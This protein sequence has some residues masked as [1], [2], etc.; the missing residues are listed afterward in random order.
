MESLGP[1]ERVPKEKAL[2]EKALQEEAMKPGGGEDLLTFGEAAEFAGV[3]LME[4][5]GSLRGAQVK[6]HWGWRGGV[7]LQLVS[8]SELESLYPILQKR[9]RERGLS[10]AERGILLVDPSGNK[11]STRGHARPGMNTHSAVRSA[12]RE[13]PKPITRSRKVEAPTILPEEDPLRTYSHG[14][15]GASARSAELLSELDQTGQGIDHLLK[16]GEGAAASPSDAKPKEAR[17]GRA[18][19]KGRDRRLSLEISDPEVSEQDARKAEWERLVHQESSLERK[20]RRV[21]WFSWTVAAGLMVWVAFQGQQMFFGKSANQF[22]TP[23]P[24]PERS[25]RWARGNGN[26]SHRPNSRPVPSDGSSLA[27][28]PLQSPFTTTGNR[29]GLV[30]PEHALA[31]PGLHS[32]DGPDDRPLDS[33]GDGRPGD[34]VP[35]SVAAGTPEAGT[36]EATLVEAPLPIDGEAIGTTEAAATPTDPGTTLLGGAGEGLLA[37]QESTDPPCR[38]HGLTG[39]GQELRSVLGPCIGPWNPKEKAV[40]GGVPAQR[41]RSLPPSLLLPA[42]R[43][44]QRRSGQQDRP[45]RKDRG[46]RSAYLAAAPR[47]WGHPTLGGQGGQVVGIGL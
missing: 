15:E 47:P 29:G 28:G 12:P 30:S 16:K 10:L 42:R 7:A 23:E 38:F 13:Q 11:P 33:N 36:E 37:L 44:R 35:A 27:G 32:E 3:S 22:T 41:P 6:P 46:P 2:Q 26:Q 18:R 1:K 21:Q 40:A 20:H 34:L 17:P 39:P 14:I 25:E 31:A 5:R 43:A 45:V 8:V 19:K 24:D 4:L 9:H